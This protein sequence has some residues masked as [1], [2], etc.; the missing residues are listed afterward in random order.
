MQKYLYNNRSYSD[1][2]SKP[3]PFTNQTGEGLGVWDRLGGGLGSV[4]THWCVAMSVWTQM[5][6]SSCEVIL[7]EDEGTQTHLILT[8]IMPFLMPYL[9]SSSRRAMIRSSSPRSSLSTACRIWAGLWGWLQGEPSPPSVWQ[10][11]RIRAC[12]SSLC[13]RV[14][15]RLM[16]EEPERFVPGSRFNSPSVQI[17]G[18]GGGGFVQRLND[19][20]HKE[21][22]EELW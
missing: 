22:F 3:S 20:Q 1:S 15:S 8:E 16:R 18:G 7:R 11:C 5:T 12:S 17:S 6:P 19:F 4:C 10:Y 21:C 13:V 14:Q 9:C 2:V